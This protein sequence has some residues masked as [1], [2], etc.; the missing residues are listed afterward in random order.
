M[1]LA[2]VIGLGLLFLTS[3]LIWP[4][5]PRPKCPQCKSTNITMIGEWGKQ[6]DWICESC[7]HYFFMGYW[8]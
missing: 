2:F 4:T 1:E 8:V 3:V 5:K 7:N 6:K